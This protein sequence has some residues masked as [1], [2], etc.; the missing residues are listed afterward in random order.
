MEQKDV[1]LQAT[2]PNSE[3]PLEMHL[4]KSCCD[5]RTQETRHCSLVGSSMPQVLVTTG[6][7]PGGFIIPN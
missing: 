7:F 3:L 2:L 6:S 5:K 4:R 1:E